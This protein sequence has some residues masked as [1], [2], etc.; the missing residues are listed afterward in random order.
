MNQPSNEH[1][2]ERRKVNGGTLGK[3]ERF[4]NIVFGRRKNDAFVTRE[5]VAE[6]GTGLSRFL[7]NHARILQRPCEVRIGFHATAALF[8]IAPT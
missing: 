2:R 5:A 3:Y 7:R 1:R 6:H 4:P 8:S